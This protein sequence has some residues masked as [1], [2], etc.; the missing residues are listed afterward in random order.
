[1]NQHWK[2]L[3]WHWHW[4]N[5]DDDSK[6]DRV[7]GAFRAALRSLGVND[8]DRWREISDVHQQ[9]RASIRGKLGDGWRRG[10]AWLHLYWGDPD[11]GGRSLTSLSAQ[12]LLLRRQHSIGIDLDVGGGDTD[13]DID[14]S[15]RIPGCGI[16]LSAEGVLP[17][18]IYNPGQKYPSARELSLSWFDQALWIHL[19]RDPDES[20]GRGG[21][22]FWEDARSRQRSITIRPL[23]ILLGRTRCQTDQLGTVI[24]ALELPEGRYVVRVVIERRTWTRPRW[25]RPVK[26]RISATVHSETGIP[27]PGKGENGWDMDEDAYYSI[28]TS[29]TTVLEALAAAKESVLKTR[30]RYGGE[31]WLPERAR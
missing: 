18:P 19:W 1:M 14:F 8:P 31:H 26:V 16:Y 30:R 7:S 22:G 9:F 28:G 23:D 17:K 2:N 11:H 13:R 5:Q 27:I 25:P 21:P 15:L 29:A 3:Y 10:S 24:T 20:Y 12:W 6:R 4:Q